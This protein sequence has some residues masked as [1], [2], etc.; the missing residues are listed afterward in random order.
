MRRTVL[1]LM[2]LMNMSA[3]AF[4]GYVYTYSG[5]ATGLI[6]DV[7]LLAPLTVASTGPLP[8]A[9]GE[10]DATALSASL[11][12]LTSN[13]VS[14]GVLNASTSGGVPVIGVTDSTASV[15]SISLLDGLITATAVSSE[16][17]AFFNGVNGSSS[18]ADLT[19]GGVGIVVSGAA[20]QTISVE[21]LGVQIATLVIN[22][23]VSSV[24]PDGSS[25]IT[26]NALHLTVVDGI[27]N[28][29]F[30]GCGDC[31]VRCRRWCSGDSRTKQ[32]GA[33]VRSVG[34]SRRIETHPFPGQN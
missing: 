2:L 17:S 7:P 31:P 1:G 28:F 22:E 18:I 6:A 5:E 26:V 9:G 29:G 25:N 19:V 12:V 27:P 24:A 33:A 34:H 13:V 20:N 15:A 11:D 4:G 8:P 23:Q 14:T 30:G 21:I 10:L 32:S 3:S 16:A